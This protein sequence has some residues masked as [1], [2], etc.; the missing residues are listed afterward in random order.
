VADLSAY[1]LTTEPRVPDAVADGADL[2]I[3][4]GD[5]LLGGPQA[6][7]LV[8]GAAILARCRANPLARAARADKMTFAALEATLELYRD[9]VVALREVPVLR[10]LTLSSDELA[11]RAE[12]LATAISSLLPA[13]PR[14]RLTEGSSVTGGG[15]F[16]AA[17]L[18]TTLVVL[19]PGPRG[20]DSLA[21][22]LRLGDPPVVAR[23]T[24]G[25]VVLDPRTLAETA[26]PDLAAAVASA[27]AE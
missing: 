14:P 3:F 11:R 4:S 9:P 17:T 2:V 10:M 7:C 5:K 24:D 1:G 15:S 22:A 8:G 18:P 19:D 13:S 12:A 25:C 20:A 27:R 6:G 21:L 16:P 23:V 26:F